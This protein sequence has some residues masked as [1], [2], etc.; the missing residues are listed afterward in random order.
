MDIL[1]FHH[2]Q[3]VF[4]CYTWS[5][6]TS[7]YSWLLFVFRVVHIQKRLLSVRVSTRKTREFSPDSQTRSYSGR[8]RQI[9]INNYPAY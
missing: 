1:H 2:D 6:P 4:R 9:L 8:K 7:F 3:H 5:H